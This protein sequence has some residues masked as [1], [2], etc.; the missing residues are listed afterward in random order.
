VI[1]QSRFELLG[2]RGVIRRNKVRD[3]GEIHLCPA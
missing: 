1:E 3:F 2:A